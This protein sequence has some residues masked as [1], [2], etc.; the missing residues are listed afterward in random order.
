MSDPA[1]DSASAEVDSGRTAEGSSAVPT[2]AADSSPPGELANTNRTGAKPE[3]KGVDRVED[4]VEDISEQFERM[5]ISN[6]QN[7]VCLSYHIYT[8]CLRQLACL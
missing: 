3:P 1:T 6:D 4:T 7:K 5:K 2:D 8:C